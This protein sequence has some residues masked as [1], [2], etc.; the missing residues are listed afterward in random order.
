MTQRI[1]NIEVKQF[2]KVETILIKIFYCNKCQKEGDIFL[3][4]KVY[5][6][7]ENLFKKQANIERVLH[8]I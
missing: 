7:G 5:E 8:N 3:F 2:S 6:K 4:Y 1:I